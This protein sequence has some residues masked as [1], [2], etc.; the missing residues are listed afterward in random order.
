MLAGLLI[1]SLAATARGIGAAE[2]I[3]FTGRVAELEG[4][5]PVEGAA[6][7]VERSIR[8]SAPAAY[9]S[10]CGETT[11]QTDADGRF[12][13][14]FPPE[15][16]A[17]RRHCIALRIRHSGFIPRKSR[18]VLLADLIREQARGEEPFFAKMT[19]ERGLEYTARVMVPGGRPAAG[20]PFAFEHGTSGTVF[21]LPVLIDDYEGE[22]DDDGRI[23]IRMPKSHALALYVGPPRTARARFPV[24]PYQ[25]FWGTDRAAG[26]P[27]V[28]A[29]TDL[30]RI[31]LSRGIRLPGRLVDAEGRP[32]AGQTITAYP[33]R[34]HD[35][36]STTT[37][38]DG[39]FSLGPLRPANYLIYGEGQGPYAD[40]DFDA[41]PHPRPI[42]VVRPLRVYLKEGAIPE[43]LVLREMPT[44][45][46][47]VRFVDSRGKPTR[48]SATRLWGLLPEDPDR[49][50]LPVPIG[51]REGPTSAINAPETADNWDPGTWSVQDQPDDE[52]RVVFYAP[53]GLR[54]ASVHTPPAEE[55]AAFKHRIDPDGP[56]RPGPPARLGVLDGDRRMTMIVYQ[57]PTILVCVK[58]EDG[59]V[60]GDLSVMARHRIDRTNYGSYFVP[61]AD[62]RYRSQSLMP[63]HEYEVTVRERGGAYDPAPVQRVSV[64]EGGSAQLSFLLRKRRKPPGV[65]QPAPPFEVRTIEGRALSLASLRGK[66]VL[67]HFWQPAPGIPDAASFRAIHDR[68]GSDERFAMIG[69]CLSDD[70]EAATRVIRSAGISWPQAM[71]R[72]RGFDR[73]VIDYG[74]LQPDR[75][76]LIGPD[77]KLIARGLGGGLLEEA[78]ARALAGK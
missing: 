19:L 52:G 70:S 25:H 20:I 56:I 47:Q 3:A 21:P 57:A 12:R 30:G 17:E 78:I 4:G 61:Q 23:R 34:G 68:F 46:V 50:I 60:P 26:Q 42:R 2:A 9:P 74:A 18:K 75:T 31:V 15:Q 49:R 1:V 59:A 65:G 35:R 40:V 67:L 55:T 6:V 71:L 27:D 24:A 28:W 53:R 72:D 29:P 16:V 45:R 13:L 76:F 64:P 66:T 22:T 44:L 63:D 32:I 5:K 51:W 62:G 43:P 58:T 8:G 73:I 37:E 48:G 36:H 38:A 14:D 11:I 39:S 54:N 33:L 69:L 77:G 10:W 7:L 41:P